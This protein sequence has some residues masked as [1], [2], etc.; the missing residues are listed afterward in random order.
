MDHQQ[1]TL[2]DLAGIGK[3]ILRRHLLAGAFGDLHHHRLLIDKAF[4]RKLGDL[5][6]VRQIVV[7]G[8]HVRTRVIIEAEIDRVRHIAFGDLEPLVHIQLRAVRPG[9]HMIVDRIRQQMI[10]GFLPL[11]CI[12][13]DR[14]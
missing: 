7:R 8:I 9:G 5:D 10:H 13:I 4:Q 14:S 1:I 2:R 6:T 3:Q 11:P 12:R